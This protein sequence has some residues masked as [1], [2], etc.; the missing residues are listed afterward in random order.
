MIRARVRANRHYTRGLTED[1]LTEISA[2]KEV[3]DKE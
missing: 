3:P 1:D 2:C